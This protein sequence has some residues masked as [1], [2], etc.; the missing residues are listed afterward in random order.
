MLLG[1]THLQSQQLPKF[2]QMHAFVRPVVQAWGTLDP[3]P[4]RSEMGCFVTAR[5]FEISDCDQ[6]IPFWR[7]CEPTSGCAFLLVD[8]V[9]Y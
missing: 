5:S 9:G 4:F 3:N 6:E 1:R 7:N 2:L 8:S